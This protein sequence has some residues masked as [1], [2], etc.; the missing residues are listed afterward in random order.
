MT[1]F[2][3]IACTLA[4]H[5]ALVHASESLRPRGSCAAEGLVMDEASLLQHAAS[6]LQHAAK[7]GKPSRAEDTPIKVE[8]NEAASNSPPCVCVDGGDGWISDRCPN[9]GQGCCG[10]AGGDKCDIGPAHPC[11][12]EQGNMGVLSSNCHRFQPLCCVDPK[13][14]EVCSHCPCGDDGWGVVGKCKNGFGCCGSKD[15]EVCNA[16]SS[17]HLLQDAAEVEKPR[18]EDTPIIKVDR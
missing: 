5:V 9:G 11:R 14:N 4:L 10:F 12:C 18:A 17:R 8:P 16:R 6:L 15:G 3:F 2:M 13:Q 7:V 1:R